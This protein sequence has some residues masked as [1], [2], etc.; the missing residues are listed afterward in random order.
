MPNVNGLLNSTVLD[1]AIGLIFIYLLLAIICTTV[2]EWISGMFKVRSKM[3]ADAIEQLLDHQPGSGDPAKQFLDQFR[4]HPLISGMLTPKDVGP[5]YL[6]SRTFAT[7]VMDIATIKKQGALSFANLDQGLRDMPDG[8]VKTA[9]LALIQNTDNDLK[10]AQENIEQWFD[11]TMDRASGWYKRRTQMVV[12]AIAVLLT[13][14]TNAD[15]LKIARILW[16]S[17]TLRATV[18]EKANKEVASQQPT[19]EYPD[20]NAPLKPKATITKDD[21]NILQQV[22]GWSGENLCD[23]IGWLQRLV[24]WILTIAAVSLGAP[25]WF[26]LLSKLMNVRNAGKKPETADQQSTQNKQTKPLAA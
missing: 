19:V 13:G 17:P 3:L 14:L 16:Q 23:W 2:N 10:T 4:G 18:V 9:L 22:L 7:T 26:D 6:A 25:F 15:T 5:S 24:G 12:I 1:V 8:D 11:D 21:M 20:K